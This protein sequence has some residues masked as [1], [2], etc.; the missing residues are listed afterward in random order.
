MK[1]PLPAYGKALALFVMLSCCVLPAVCQAQAQA[2]VQAE[3]P[4]I[5]LHHTSWTA[6]DGAPALVLSM[7][8]T[9]DGWLWLGGPTGLYRFDGIQFEQ[10]VP[11]NAPLL[12]RN[13]SVVN[14]FA[15]GSLWIGYRTGGAA[16]LQN[17]RIR[18]YGERDGLPARAVWGVEQDS[19]G[20]IWAAT[21]LGMR[22]LEQ[23]HWRPPASSWNLPQTLYKTLI[24]DRQGVLWAQGEA[25]VFFLKPGA[26]RFERAAVDSGTG[27]LFNLTR[28]SVVSWNAI[29]GRFRQVAGQPQDVRPQLWQ[30]LGD[31]ASLLFDR[32]GDLW[33]GTRDGLEYHTPQ[34]IARTLP[35]QGLSGRQVS[36]LFEDREGN[37]WAATAGGVDRF[38]RRRLTRIAVP[39]AA[40]GHAILADDNGGAWI[41]GFHVA[42]GDAGLAKVTPLWPASSDGWSGMLTSFT[43]TSDGVLW[44]STY[45]ALRRVQGRDSRKIALPPFAGGAFV[46]L[47]QAD[48]DNS[49]LVSLKQHGLYRRKPGGAWE[50][51]GDPGEVTVMARSDAAGLWLACFAGN[52]VHA[53]GAQWRSYGAPQGLSVGLVMALHLHGLH[54]WA[55]GDTGLAWLIGERFRPV[56]GVKGETFDGISGIVE[57]DNGDLWLN[58]AAGLFR[59]P[60]AELAKVQR[61]P[62]YR[63][64][65]ERLDQLDGMDGVAPRLVP[66]PSMVL[67]SD[68]RLWV[69]RSSGV[70][71]LNPAEPPP[72]APAQPVII[73][74]IGASGASLPLQ[75]P[76][77][78]AAGSSVVQ[79]DYTVPALALPERVR[80]RYR[81]DE[82]DADWQE[83]GGRRSAYLSNLGAG[84]YHFRVAA[85]D[86]NGQWP[87]RETLLHFTIAPAI[88]ETWWFRALCGVLLLAA[89]YLSYRWHLVRMRRQMANRLRE[90]VNERERIAR[91]LHDTLLQSVQ[92]LILHVH[93]ATLRLPDQDSTRL[94]LETA[95]LQ[96]DNVV[97]EGRGR[98]SGL[99]G[100]DAGKANFPDAVLAAAT[101]LR[102]HDAPPV[103]LSLV[104]TPRRLD[105]TMHEEAI[106][107]VTEAIA[108]AYRHAGAGRI[109]V[110]LQYGARELRCTVRDDGAGIAA[111]V[112]RDGGRKHHWGMR[113]M[114]ERASRINAKLVLRSGEGSGTEWQL[115]L[116]ATLAYTR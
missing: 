56:R 79:I 99:R 72:P 95:L 45:G 111:D 64:Q 46:P 34:G 93:A 51:L 114:T 42:A 109:E 36:A 18:N 21:P 13:V 116:P 61:S 6:R 39:E 110:E 89:A 5:N 101:R 43:R 29:Q 94:Q 11:S 16:R 24:R 88:T 60:G 63:V 4:A 48:R 73:K 91:E 59:I 107:I 49:V 115:V 31:P 87:E 47:V 83:V 97:D 2:P 14:A 33:V 25:G 37:I 68:G 100:E 10:F 113:G 84:D 105:P 12:T 103:Q 62:D 55:G 65:Y 3:R 30:H 19:S 44:G 96:A 74:R 106:A 102:P 76:V 54:V 53:D 92:G 112:L 86:Y 78:F 69:M 67:A 32:R 50:K 41:G 104:G 77:R 1:R 38:A 20:R 57:L 17:G 15:D 26:A 52:L 85:S 23:D 71:R 75:Q 80:F 9:T 8:Q 40:I 27:V 28:D 7:T 70:F 35:A 98:I 108:N 81:L 90:R 58:A 66:S 22:Y 82:T